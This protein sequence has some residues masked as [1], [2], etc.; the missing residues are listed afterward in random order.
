MPDGKE[1]EKRKKKRKETTLENSHVDY[2]SH[3]AIILHDFE[4]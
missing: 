1:R 4:N 2:T 3:M